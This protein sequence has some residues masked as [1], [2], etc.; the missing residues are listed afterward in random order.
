MT[1][2]KWFLLMVLTAFAGFI[3]LINTNSYFA[4][5]YKV[6]WL[7][8]VIGVAAAL[9]AI[10]SFYNANKLGNKRK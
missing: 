2:K 8:I 3:L 10:Y 7:F 9:V 6:G 4:D 1:V 5:K